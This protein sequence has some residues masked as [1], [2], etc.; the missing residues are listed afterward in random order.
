MISLVTS[1]AI[2]ESYSRRTSAT[3][4]GGSVVPIPGQGAEHFSSKGHRGGG[5]LARV[6]VAVDLDVRCER[7]AGAVVG[8]QRDEPVLEQ[9]LGSIGQSVLTLLGVAETGQ[10]ISG[11]WRGGVLP[12]G[13]QKRGRT[14]ADERER[15]AGGEH[16][17]HQHPGLEVG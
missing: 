13:G 16:P 11:K 10:P 8:A 6:Q 5:V 14:V 17:G 12:G 4:R 2:P 1:G 7:L 3:F 15:L 9:P